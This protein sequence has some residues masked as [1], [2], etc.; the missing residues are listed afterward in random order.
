MSW[1]SVFRDNEKRFVVCCLTNVGRDRNALS[2][3]NDPLTSVVMLQMAVV[4]S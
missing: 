4:M 2:H 3:N 1:D